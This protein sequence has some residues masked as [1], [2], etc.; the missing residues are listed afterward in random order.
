MSVAEQYS[1]NEHV[2]VTSEIIGSCIKVQNLSKSF[3]ANQVLKGVSLKIDEGS[4]VSL[5]GANGS[6]KSTLLRSTVRLI[7]PDAGEAYLFGT[8]LNGLSQSK[9]S[10]VRR[11]VGFVFQYHN[12]ALRL[13]ALSNVIH[14]ALGRSNSPRLWM[15]G[16]APQELREQA[17]E[18]LNTVGL[19]H[20]ARRQVR[21]LSGGQSQRVAVARALMQ[22][23]KLIIADEP[24]ASL[25]PQS[26]E[27]IMEL[28]CRLNQENGITI[29]FT[30]HNLEHATQYA[31]RI[32]GL[33]SG[34]L[35]LDQATDDVSIAELRGF[36][37]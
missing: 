27:E 36:Y 4:M 24:V 26:G 12:L 8:K 34:V 31:Q 14:G 20:I 16:F 17:L 13:S 10:K 19:A 37:E 11:N 28:F 1:V 25:D 3:G 23:P 21:H 29:V 5:I 2:K 30:S 32:V 15:Q 7:E 22:K 6:G 18:C 35:A 33:Q 9:I